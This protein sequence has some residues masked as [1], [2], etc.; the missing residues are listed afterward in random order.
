MEVV[1]K[2][3]EN[4]QAGNLDTVP[5][6]SDTNAISYGP[7][8]GYAVMVMLLWLWLQRTFSQCMQV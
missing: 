1:A 3:S 2:E 5:V 4:M 7:C 8:Y 6:D